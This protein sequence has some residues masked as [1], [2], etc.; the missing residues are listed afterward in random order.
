MID[1]R[2]WF[3]RPWWLLSAVFLAVVAAAGVAFAV[4][5]GDASGGGASPGHARH[6][7]PTDSICG[8][9]RGNQD[10]V[11]SPPQASWT[12]S[13]TVA[14]PSIRG[15]GPGIID[16]Q[17]RRCFA[18]SPVGATLAAANYVAMAGLPNGALTAAQS[19][20]HIVPGHVRDVYARHPTPETPPAGRFQI[21]GVRVDVVDPD[22][23]TVTLAVRTYGGVLAS[24]QVPMVYMAGD[25]RVR[26]LSIDEPYVIARLDSL[27][28]FIT[29]SGI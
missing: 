2:K 6:A 17:D 15:V 8:L 3:T 22:N 7:P 27:D 12:L 28:G 11:V 24:W 9:P 25:W 18:H 23:V 29:W 5:G 14:T 26:L 16:G 21:A 10:P 4:T 20:A 1:E 19:L 13:G